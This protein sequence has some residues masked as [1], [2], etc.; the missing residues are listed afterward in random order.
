VKPRP[1]GSSTRPG[2]ARLTLSEFSDRVGAVW[3]A[4]TTVQ[5][6]AATAGI[7]LPP[8]VGTTK[9]VSRVVSVMGD[10]R[11]AGRWRLPRRLSAWS[12]MGDVHLD[13]TSVVCAETEVELRLT[14]VMGDVEVLLP[15][16]IEVELTGF[17]LMGDREL[18]LAPV[19][20]LPGTPLI[21]VRAH[22]VMGDVLIRSAGAPLE[23]R[24]GWRRWLGVGYAEP[25]G[26][27]EISP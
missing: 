21:R 24:K 11:R 4:E 5:L 7:E 27:E 8:P 13:L 6:T 9:T 1:S 2:P 16:G 15:D 10:T 19:P 25:H 17:D 3:A 26:R 20:R 18:V 12:V 22:A 23:R 14:S